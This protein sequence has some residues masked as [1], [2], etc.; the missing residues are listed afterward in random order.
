MDLTLKTK[1]VLLDIHK[2]CTTMTNDPPSP[3]PAQRTPCT[4]R[5]DPRT[6]RVNPR[7]PHTNSRQELPVLT[8][9][10]AAQINARYLQRE[11]IDSHGPVPRELAELMVRNN[12]TAARRPISAVIAALDG[13][14]NTTVTMDG[15]DPP[16]PSSNNNDPTAMDTDETNIPEGRL[17]TFA[18]IDEDD[19]QIVV[20][21]AALREVLAVL[22]KYFVVYPQP[23]TYT[24]SI[25]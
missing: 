22:G 8:P 18:E 7:T 13:S 21:P 10:L 15:R 24:S 1:I 9:E 14:E 25:L 16:M 5:I 2:S 4:P 20:N 3:T 23:S 17:L 12:R 11:R 6:P 19:D